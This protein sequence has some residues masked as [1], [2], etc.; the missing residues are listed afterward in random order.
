MMMGRS[1]HYE[2]ALVLELLSVVVV[3]MRV[4]VMLVV[5]C[6]V[7]GRVARMGLGCRGKR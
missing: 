4:V 5:G 1:R 6:M 2:L 7:V 3:V